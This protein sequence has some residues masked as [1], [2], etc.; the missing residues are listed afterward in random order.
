MRS[1]LL[2]LLHQAELFR[3]G[4][5]QLLPL[6]R[7]QLFLLPEPGLQLMLAHVLGLLI[8]LPDVGGIHGRISHLLDS[9]TRQTSIGGTLTHRP[10][11]SKREL[12]SGGRSRSSP[13]C[14]VVGPFS[15]RGYSVEASEC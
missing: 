15:G 8:A 10:V 12:I 4:G 1:G 13:A 7:H 2:L 6:M 5:L 9:L 14:D 3:E 11:R